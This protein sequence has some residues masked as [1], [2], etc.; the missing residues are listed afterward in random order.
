MLK[1]KIPEKN[2]NRESEKDP[3]K[4]KTKKGENRQTIDNIPE[5]TQK[6]EI[7]AQPIRCTTI[8]K[9]RRSQFLNLEAKY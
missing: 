2:K 1:K 5:S 4:K 9:S 3:Q 6:L 7:L 8:M